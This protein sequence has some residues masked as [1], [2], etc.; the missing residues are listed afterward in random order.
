MTSPSSLIS[1][2][3][4]K[5][6]N[7]TVLPKTSLIQVYL[8]NQSKVSSNNNNNNNKQSILN[9]L[10]VG[11]SSPININKSKVL[12]KFNNNDIVK[13][14]N[15]ITSVPVIDSIATSATTASSLTLSQIKK[16]FKEKRFKEF[17]RICLNQQNQSH[18]EFNNGSSKQNEQNDFNTDGSISEYKNDNN[19]NRKNLFSHLAKDFLLDCK[20]RLDFNSY[21]ILLNHLN[22]YNKEDQND[23]ILDHIF[24]L[25]KKD[26]NLCTKFSAFL[27]SENSIKYDLFIQTQQYEKTY[28]FLNKLELFIPN[29]LAFKKLLQTFIASSNIENETISSKIDEIKA[30]IKQ[31]LKNNAFINMELD[32][33]FDQRHANLEPTFE[34]ISLLDENSNNTSRVN[35][36]NEFIDLTNFTH[37]LDYGTKKCSCKCHN[38]LIASSNDQNEQQANQLTNDEYLPSNLN[39]CLL[40]SLKLVKGKLCIKCEGKKGV[41][42]I[43]KIY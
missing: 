29:K 22:D 2:Q 9:S 13:H 25:I 43:Y 33:L 38:D 6:K 23:E 40:C 5:N 16:S 19:N 20:Q 28:E 34:K 8:D 27:T 3:K 11:N 14:L 10:N 26:K 32:Y 30:K 17:T 39:H 31:T 36:E 15:L 42:L 18:H 41:P 1:I 4:Q 7:K 12:P 35:L 21:K 24:E 37:S